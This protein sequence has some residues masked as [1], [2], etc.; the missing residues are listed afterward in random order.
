MVGRLAFHSALALAFGLIWEAAASPE[1]GWL[2]PALVGRPMRALGELGALLGSAAFWPHVGVTLLEALLGLAWALVAALALALAFVARPRLGAL[3]DPWLNALN[4]LPKLALAPFLVVWVGIG[5][6]S[7]VWV[8]ASMA[9]FP[10]FYS[11]LAGLRALDPDMLAAHRLMGFSHW[12]LVGSVALPATL[13]WTLSSLRAAIG[14][15]LTGAVVGEFVGA[16]QGLGY[17]LVGAQG[18]M[19]THRALA[20][21]VV[22]AAL[23]ATLDAGARRLERWQ[24]GLGA[25]VRK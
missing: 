7:K 4:A 25:A 19:A 8:A 3:L 20:L 10:L 5:L 17:L 23:G 12:R 21:L 6:A 1:L 24:P 18:F 9:F 22:L 14:L 2:N 15:A 13:G 11:T 16:T